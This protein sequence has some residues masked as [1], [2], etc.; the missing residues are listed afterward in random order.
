M[1]GLKEWIDDET[2][3]MVMVMV[4]MMGEWNGERINGGEFRKAGHY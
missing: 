4:M 3:M 1:V 2:M